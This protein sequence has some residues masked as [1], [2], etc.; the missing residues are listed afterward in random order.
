MYEKCSLNV[1]L[2]VTFCV[3]TTNWYQLNVLCLSPYTLW[4]GMG[5]HYF[6]VYDACVYDKGRWNLKY[7]T[8]LVHY[9]SK[10]E[11][12]WVYTE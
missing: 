1:H 10:K 9:N 4:E 3:K 5:A 7:D 2:K 11:K 12:E 6:F 8:L